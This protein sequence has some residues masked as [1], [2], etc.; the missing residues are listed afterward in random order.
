MPYRFLSH[1]DLPFEVLLKPKRGVRPDLRTG[2]KVIAEIM[3]WS[4]GPIAIKAVRLPMDYQSKME[5]H[6]HLLSEVP[7]L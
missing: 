5:T 2:D 7:S 4:K 3:R 1:P 6:A